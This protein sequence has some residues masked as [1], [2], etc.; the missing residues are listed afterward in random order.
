MH[1]QQDRTSAGCLPVT[2]TPEVT[3]VIPTRNE[4]DSIV[5]LLRQLD[6]ALGQID[7]HILFVDD[8]DDDTPLVI[9]A[10]AE[11]LPRNVKVIHR[12]GSDR[13]GGLGGAVAAGLRSAA[14]PWVV[15]LD[16]DL[17]HPPATV[18]VLLE[19]A[20]SSDADLV[21]ATRYEGHGTASGLGGGLRSGVSLSCNL[22][23]RGLFPVRLKNVSD[24]MSGFF[25]VRLDKIDLDRF[26]PNG[27]K[28]LLELL[29]TQRIRKVA[30]V[31]F[32]FQP[33]FAGESKASLREGF[34]FLGQ[35]VSVRVGMS[36][37]RLAQMVGFL[38]VGLLG[39]GVNT[40]AL[41]GLTDGPPHLPYLLGSVIATQVAVV[42]NFLLLESL[43]FAGSRARSGVRAFG[44]FWLVS[45]V[46][47]P[48]QLA[49]LALLVEVFRVP[50]VLANVLVLGV[51][52]VLRY[53]AT[54]GWVYRWNP[55]VGDVAAE[56]VP[57]KSRPRSG[58]RP[59]IVAMA[60]VP[61]ILALAVCP[62]VVRVWWA[63]LGGQAVSALPAVSVVVVVGCTAALVV[64]KCVPAP[65]EPDV[66]DRQLDIILTIPVLAAAVWL[67]LGWRQNWAA[68]HWSTTGL[69]ALVL[70]GAAASFVLLGTRTT[71]RMRWALGLPLCLLPVVQVH[72]WLQV[73]LLAL[74][75]AVTAR[76]VISAVP[77]N[78]KAL[79]PSGSASV[80]PTTPV[81]PP[82]RW[83]AAVVTVVALL[84]GSITIR[85]Q[86]SPVDT[87]A[88]SSTIGSTP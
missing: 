65:D 6:Q 25:A 50:P 16:G 8:S 3:V 51:V 22:I 80:R 43:V 75:V 32:S 47:L 9:A 26:R 20:R 27:F 2:A 64:L 23:S 77:R 38:A 81:R 21:Y 45:M 18:P 33:R 54:S 88:G 10:A 42:T 11:S 34:R 87:A 28:V 83:A 63:M 52:F 84:I 62:G 37:S 14:S 29:A 17:Q 35:L 67:A 66:H 69:L 55:I 4:S 30:S 12:V 76:S 60:F 61:F 71:A 1:V 85:Q 68:G 73:L 72:P 48:V 49:L 5:E 31:P 40:A 19:T 79:R 56:P 46:L 24:P 59:T 44:R 13:S 58:R 70:F 86:V 36:P 74:V 41:W 57:T 78:F 53:V 15:V 7:A 82:W 39:V